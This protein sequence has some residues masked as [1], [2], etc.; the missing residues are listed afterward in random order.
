MEI[1]GDALELDASRRPAF[2]NQVCGA[3]PDLRA[4]VERLLRGAGDAS[5]AIPTAHGARQV[6]REFLPPTRI[7]PYRI[8][9][10]LGEGG[11]GVVYLGL[12]DEPVRR[13]VAIKLIRP[14][15]DSRE[16]VQRFES[17][18]QALALMSH[19]NVA[20]VYDAGADELGRPYF[21]MEY[22]D[23]APITEWCDKQR[24]A[25]RA[26]LELFLQVCDAVQ[27]AHAKGIVHR[28]L[29]PTNVLVATREGKPFPKVIDFGIAK[30]V[31]RQHGERQML[32]DHGQLVG[33][34][35]Y[36]S[37]EQAAGEAD[38]DTRTDVYALGVML[39]E[40]LS[41][42][43]PFDRKMLR[44]SA[45]E[46]MRRIIREADA[47]RPSTRLSRL[48]PN[49]VA[50]IARRR[51]LDPSSLRRVLR[52]DLDWITMKALE[53]DRERRYAS[54]GELAA[55]V[56]RH[57]RSEPV[58]AGPPTARYRLGK[59]VR[60]H[61]AVVIAGALVF[62]ALVGGIVT[63]AS[64]AVRATRAEYHARTE[65]QLAKRRFNELRK[66]AGSFMFEV[67]ET[68]QTAGPTKAREKLVNTAR[69][70]LDALARE[71]PTEPALTREL[72]QGYLRVGSVQYYPGTAHLGDVAGA[73]DSY[74]KALDLARAHA[75][76][77]PDD[78]DAARLLGGCYVY[79][80][81]A[82]ADS[83]DAGA[84]LGSFASARETYEALV[85]RKPNEFNARRNIGLVCEKLANL[86]KHLGRA[87]DSLASRRES[88]RVYESLLVERP[89]D[90]M[91]RRDVTLAHD[92]LATLLMDMG[93]VVEALPHATEALEMAEA[94]LRDAPDN[95]MLRR[96]VLL[97]S[98]HIATIQ[99][100]LG[101]A[102]LAVAP[103]RRAVEIAR[104]T[105]QAD[106]SNK[107][108]V[109]DVGGAHTTLG[110]ALI[111]A[112]RT[113]EAVEALRQSIDV[114]AAL[115]EQSPDDRQLLGW[116]A[117]ARE[118]LAAAL[119]QAGNLAEAQAEAQ[120]SVDMRRRRVDAEPHNGGHVSSLIE[121]ECELGQVLLA[122]D[123]NAE[124][125]EHFE[126]ATSLRSPGD[127]S[128]MGDDAVLGR[129]FLLPLLVRLG[130]ARARVGEVEGSHAPLDEAIDLGRRIL[131]ISQ[132]D[133]WTRAMLAA[134]LALRGSTEA[135]LAESKRV[136][137]NPS[138]G[139]EAAE[140]LWHAHAAHARA[141]A[142]AGR[143]AEAER[144]WQAALEAARRMSQ[145]D[146]DDARARDLV[147]R[148][149][150]RR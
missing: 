17:E 45:H 10:A 56:Q 35:E 123:R 53:K 37:P 20:H 117:N 106:A 46:E 58:V 7:G 85:R 100:L 47:A 149:A 114:R 87:A 111:P 5:A 144:S 108:A 148:A 93:R 33:T 145:A 91:L 83:N 9:R 140:A 131:A 147:E 121:A 115:L 107:Q 4:E 92:G 90:A 129:R 120:A 116:I 63:T 72:V 122:Q 124:A 61:R 74:R 24:L 101:H 75:A 67:D 15:M 99:R 57:L 27:H 49:T 118:A 41:G 43:L 55:D 77:R 36:I 12:Q 79:L 146:P 94:R 150:R 69:Q 11:M 104:A 134:A 130:E 54:P 112:G 6:A 82:Q 81:E 86:Y 125:L 135:A 39:Y 109:R 59:F 142:A 143:D 31:Q 23:G 14:G 102:P 65:E 32:T 34:P 138:C 78:A 113:R 1:L 16:I 28:D 96:D 80:A 52:G 139:T 126:R 89:N 8:E 110:E 22:V 26:R 19:P 103:A 40:L 66:L 105:A 127:S 38:I 119:R 133:D 48:E 136:A 30:A 25:P 141:C 64:Q 132:G 50:R 60:R 98:Q 2:L 18:R 73:L 71:S 70:Y 128:E 76:A 62:A 29:K 51:N 42:A 97:L 88:V 3:D 137:S 13:H 84:A 21:V 68:L 44:G 95:P